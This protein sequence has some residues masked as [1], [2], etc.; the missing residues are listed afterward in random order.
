MLNDRLLLAGAAILFSGPAFAQA[1]VEPGRIPQQF[2]P[3]PAPRSDMKMPQ[4]DIPETAAPS[5]AA[6]IKIVL[7][8]VQIEGASAYPQSGFAD[9]TAPMLG[10]EIA[11]SDVFALADKITARYRSNDF[12]LSRAVVP[13]QKL[14]NG[15][16]HIRVIEGYIAD[17]D[18]DGPY[19]AVL[20][21]YA[22]NLMAEHPVKGA[23]LERYLLLM[24]GVPGYSVRAV[25]APASGK[26]GGTKITII[27]SRKRYDG[28]ASIDNFG[29]RYIG[30]FESS[31]GL[32]FNDI[33]G[34]GE[35]T[36]LSYS[37]SYPQS[38]LQYFSVREDLP[39]GS[40]GL[41]LTVSGGLSNSKPGFSLRPLDA[42]ARGNNIG[43]A[44]SYPVLRSRAATWTLSA[45]AD[46]IDSRSVMYDNPA[47]APSSLDHIRALRFN[48]SY[49]FADTWGGHTLIE[50]EFSIGLEALGASDNARPNPSRPGGR[51]D[52]RKLTLDVSRRQELSVFADNLDLVLAADVQSSM[53][54]KLLSTEQFGA[55]GSVFGRGYEPSEIT[56]DDGF[57]A[58]AEVQYSLPVEAMKGGLQFFTFYDCAAVHNYAVQPGVKQNDSLSSAGLGM[59][60]D[61]FEHWS[62]SVGVEKPLTKEIETEHQA[63]REGKPWRVH[64]SLM[65]RF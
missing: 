57:A 34:L 40:D 14:E 22:Q 61:M 23:V 65:L 63:G 8:A 44:L 27:S 60:F 6:K 29:S 31:V 53:G 38:E 18:F 15:V 26:T 46:A 59:R 39:L 12:I 9:L 64:F 5:E 30:P 52:F 13:A 10:H 3:P 21:A 33:T 51:S 1:S 35:R 49:D 50:N 20:K 55:G 24:N 58:K 48:S 45:K 7:K 47:Q 19:N 36:L 56:G 28:Y 41:L 32:A 16:L 2:Q 42:K 37:F 62:G 54:Q 25:L 43:L 17:V 11:L 4:I